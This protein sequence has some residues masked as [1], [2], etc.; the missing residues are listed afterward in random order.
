M[1]PAQGEG[2]ELLPSFPASPEQGWGRL[3]V[4]LARQFL[5]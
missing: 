4:V 5:A 3:A 1:A 2:L